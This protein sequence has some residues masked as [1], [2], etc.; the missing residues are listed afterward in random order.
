MGRSSQQYNNWMTTNISNHY[1]QDNAEDDV[2]PINDR[3]HVRNLVNNEETINNNESSHHI[4][5]N[6]EEE[7][8]IRIV[9]HEDTNIDKEEIII[10]DSSDSDK[11]ENNENDNNEDDISIHASDSHEEVYMETM[12]KTILEAVSFVEAM[13]V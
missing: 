3:F 10:I 1:H 9:I 13:E 6:Q 8:T 5:L 11:E 2:N 7:E 12:T 4:C